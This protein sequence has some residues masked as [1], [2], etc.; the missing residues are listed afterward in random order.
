VGYIYK[1]PKEFPLIPNKDKIN[2]NYIPVKKDIS[3][4]IRSLSIYMKSENGEGIYGLGNIISEN[5]IKTSEIKLSKEFKFVNR[6]FYQINIHLDYAGRFPFI[7]IYYLRHFP[8][9]NAKWFQKPYNEYK[10]YWAYKLNE[11]IKYIWSTFWYD[12]ED[13]YFSKKHWKYYIHYLREKSIENY[14]NKKLPMQQKK[15]S[16]CTLEYEEPYYLEIHDTK[17]IKFNN[18]YVP[19]DINDFIVVC[20]NCHK[21]L[22]MKLRKTEN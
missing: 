13:M 7:D 1:L 14:W 2:L 21:E 11:D 19:V 10:L 8:S 22:H 17:E 16:V 12:F 3:P 9:Y 15:C 5:V 4:M 18:D 20:P 6:N